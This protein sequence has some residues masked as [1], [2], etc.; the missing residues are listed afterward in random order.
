MT[1]TSSLTMS[2]LEYLVHRSGYTSSGEK[3]DVE[4]KDKSLFG[5]PLSSRGSA[6]EWV[7]GVTIGSQTNRRRQRDKGI[8]RVSE[9]TK[10]RSKEPYRIDI[11]ESKKNHEQLY[12]Q[13][14]RRETYEYNLHLAFS[15]HCK[16]W[17]YNAPE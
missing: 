8:S 10:G 3:K 6:N 16:V 11:V 4:T 14:M 1:V 9:Q 7:D 2:E 15:H 17:Q 12:S 5:A 13:V